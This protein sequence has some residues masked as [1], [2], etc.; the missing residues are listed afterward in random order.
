MRWS[1]SAIV[2]T[3]SRWR[4]S[5]PPHGCDH[6]RPR[7]YSSA[8]ATGSGF[9]VAAAAARSIGTRPCEPRSRGRTSC[10]TEDER[11]FFD[12][13][14]VFAGGFDLRAAET[15][16]GFDPI[17]DVDVLD[18]VSSL[19]DKSMIVADR[20][21]AG[22]RYR[23]LE[24]LR[25]YGEDQMELRVETTLFRDRHATHYADLV[26]ELDVLVRGRVSDR[27]R[28]ADVDRMGQ[29]PRRAPVV[30]G[31]S[32]ISTSPSGSPRAASTTPASA[33]A[34]NMPRCCSRTVQLGDECG[35]PST[36]ML[37]MLSLLGGAARRRSRGAAPRPARPRCRTLTATIPPPRAAGGRSPAAAAA[38]IAGIARGA[39][40][41]PTSGRG[42]RQHRRS[43][44]QL[45]GTGAA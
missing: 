3:A 30:V 43:R 29:S 9:C 15:V 16:C 10:S 8:C 6:C 21:D 20:G 26:G 34:T 28:D 14:S 35:R 31:A 5:S 22:M 13:A 25:Q 37:G 27:G 12:R 7:S 1:R 19:V 2:S 24:T 41:L 11:L 38:V 4:S 33:C 36:T 40:R 17:D 42:R 45:V 18:L 32:A 44:P 23:L 39:D